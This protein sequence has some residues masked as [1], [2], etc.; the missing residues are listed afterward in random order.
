MPLKP[1]QQS[2]KPGYLYQGF[3]WNPHP[4]PLSPPPTVRH[5]LLF[6][7]FFGKR[8]NAIQNTDFG[9]HIDVLIGA[10]ICR[11]LF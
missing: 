5:W 9:V 2:L 8:T 7:L 6:N 1:G 3:S 11:S 10:R 4:P